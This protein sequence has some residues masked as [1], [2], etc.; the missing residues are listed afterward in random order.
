MLLT[1][2]IIGATVLLLLSCNTKKDTQTMEN[3]FKEYLK[4]Y[5]AKYE[6]LNTALNKAYFEASVN[7]KPEMWDKVT[8]L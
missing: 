4:G 6:P 5:I 3:E 2:V 8:K 1:A 7:S